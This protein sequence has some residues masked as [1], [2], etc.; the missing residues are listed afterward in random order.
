MATG[1]CREW[2]SIIKTLYQR[3]QLRLQEGKKTTST[4]DRYFRKAETNLYSELAYALDK[5]PEE[6]QSF[7][8]TNIE[9]VPEIVE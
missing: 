8:M 9:Q 5:Q 7:I 1:D 4:D 3:R 6:M 2:V